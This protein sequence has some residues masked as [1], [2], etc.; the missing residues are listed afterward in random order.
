MSDTFLGRTRAWVAEKL[1]PV[2]PSIARDAGYQVPETIVD[3]ERAYRDVEV[4]RRAV[5]II[6]NACANVPLTID[7]G[8]APKKLN[9]LLNIT[10]N[11][12]ED[13]NRIFRR[14]F[15]DFMLDGNAFF[16]YDGTSLYALPANEVAIQP[17][18]KT[19]VKNYQY[20]LRSGSVLYGFD[21]PKVNNI[22]FDP[23]EIIHVKSDNEDSI[24][25]GS[26]RLKPLRRLIELYYALTD[27]QRQFFKN[28]A[29]PGMVLQTDSVLSQKVKERLLEAWRNT[30]SNVFQGARSPA[31]LDGGLKIEKF[32]NIN[33][34][35]LDFEASVDRLQQDM[36]KA[37]GV[38][39]VLLKSGNNANIEVNERLLY[40]HVVLPI[41]HSYCSAF[42]LYFAGDVKIYPD[43]YSIS[44]LQPDNK[45]QA[46]YYT[47]LVN[48]GIISPNEA[49]EGLRLS[50]STDPEM[51]KIRV[52]Q[53][54]V[55]SATDPSQGGRPVEEDRTEP[56]TVTPLE[57]TNTQGSTNG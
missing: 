49:R 11:P 27:F 14:S 22:N 54:I 8:A 36:C 25:R 34:R 10:P 26:S 29:I 50:R 15:L 2:Q 47:T 19:F 21:K 6:I 38:P 31:I 53:N 23:D 18:E 56:T 12:F 35:E 1:N 44:A 40:N 13:R 41:L 43:K 24:F 55:G 9:K 28:N 17:D 52:P 39:Y 5:D 16:Y 20:Q 45:T 46:M 37:L 48:G 42:Q 57:D 4:I 32:S 30:Y 51:D 3:F 7:G 33:F